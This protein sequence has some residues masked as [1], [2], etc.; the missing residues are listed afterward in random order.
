MKAPTIFGSL[1]WMV[2]LFGVVGTAMVGTA[3]AGTAMAGTAVTG[4]AMAGS[5][6]I[7][8]QEALLRALDDERH[9]QAMYRAVIDQ[10]GEVMP[11]AHVIQAEARHESR[12]LDLL[13]KYQVEIPADP[14]PGRE[15]ES[16]G[17][18]DEAC[19]QAVEAEKANIGMYDELLGLELPRDIRNVFTRLRSASEEHHL[20]AF[21]RCS[22]SESC[23]GCGR[24]GGRGAGRGKSCGR[25]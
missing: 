13:E 16:E 18:V 17:T 22:Q 6:D 2:V 15:L 21:G 24:G 25:R 20:P 1:V 9:A 8:T 5:L 4:T 23:Q 19:A 10:H 3:M 11:F 12:V 7:Q 14:W